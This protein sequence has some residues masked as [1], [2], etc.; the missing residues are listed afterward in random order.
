MDVPQARAAL[1]GSMIGIAALAAI[2]KF[3]LASAA[4]GLVALVYGLLAVVPGAVM[5]RVLRKIK[6][7]LI[8]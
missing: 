6:R 1:L 3:S 8:G 4:I 7:W 2:S 5:Y